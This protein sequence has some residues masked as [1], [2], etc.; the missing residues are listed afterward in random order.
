MP[1]GI[2]CVTNTSRACASGTAPSPRAASV[3]RRLLARA[4]PGWFQ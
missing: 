3:T 1:S 4:N 2:E